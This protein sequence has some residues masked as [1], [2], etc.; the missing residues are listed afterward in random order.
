VVLWG[1]SAALAD[2]VVPSGEAPAEAR[3]VFT[4]PADGDIVKSPVIV[5]FALTGMDLASPDGGR[6]EKACLHLI[7]DAPLPDLSR[8]I[9]ENEQQHHFDAE[10]TEMTLELHPG[11]HTLQLIAGDANHVPHEPPVTSAL[12]SIS[13]SNFEVEQIESAESSRYRRS[14][15]LRV[16]VPI[17]A[18]LPEEDLEGRRT[19]REE[20]VRTLKIL[21]DEIHRAKR[22][23]AA[24]QQRDL[25][26]EVEETTRDG[27]RKMQPL[28]YPE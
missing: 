19:R 24:E 23:R 26:L 6:E 11:S 18:E 22:D 7:V 2:E 20:K 17:E 28:E 9:L 10:Q 1:T 16:H 4:S 27:S 21:V 3:V 12:I 13:V 8:P 15:N 5:Q 14:V 25:T